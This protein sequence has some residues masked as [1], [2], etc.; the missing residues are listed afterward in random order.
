[1][2]SLEVRKTSLVSAGDAQF[3]MTREERPRLTILAQRGSRAFSGF[4]GEA[5]AHGSGT[6]LLCSTSAGNATALRE[7]FAWLQPRPLGVGTSAG[8]GDRL[9]P[10]TPGDL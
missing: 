5:S 3:G 7:V 2:N 10:P 4:V 9:G 1:M 6:L 8:L